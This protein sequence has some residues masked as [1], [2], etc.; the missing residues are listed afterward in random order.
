MGETGIVKSASIGCLGGRQGVSGDARSEPIRHGQGLVA[1]FDAEHIA[2]HLKPSTQK[3]YQRKCPPKAS[4]PNG[5]VLIP[6]MTVHHSRDF[7]AK[8]FLTIQYATQ[9]KNVQFSVGWPLACT[10]LTATVGKLRA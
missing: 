3:E 2:V 9:R 5:D 7:T 10:P 8:R 4:S 1:Q 6:A